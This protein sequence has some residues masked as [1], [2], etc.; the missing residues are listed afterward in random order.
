[1][2]MQAPP[3]DYHARLLVRNA[4][5]RAER[6]AKQTAE[7]ERKRAEKERKR[8]VP[9]RFEDLNG[10]PDPDRWGPLYP[11]TSSAAVKKWR[12]LAASRPLTDAETREYGASVHAWTRSRLAVTPAQ[13]LNHK[14]NCASGQSGTY[15][16]KKYRAAMIAR[17]NEQAAENRRNWAEGKAKS[18][19]VGQ[20][21]MTIGQVYAQAMAEKA[22]RLALCRS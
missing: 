10:K 15:N 20:W 1:M 13:G 21:D 12:A 5:E 17:L 3:S 14:S 19:L 7:K 9:F 18:G 2:N 22:V 8:C 4:A 6:L 11:D 16:R